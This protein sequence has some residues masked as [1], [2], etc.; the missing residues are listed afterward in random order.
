MSCLFFCLFQFLFFFVYQFIYLFVSLFMNHK[1]SHVEGLNLV[2]GLLVT[3]ISVDTVSL[4]V[5]QDK[6][7]GE[8]LD[9]KCN[10]C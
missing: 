10:F 5:H 1:Q 7:L 8:S 2:D 4:V 3:L 6:Q 9:T